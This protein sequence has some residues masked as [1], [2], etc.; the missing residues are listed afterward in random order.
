MQPVEMI[1]RNISKED[2]PGNN[3]K[4]VVSTYAHT[5]QSSLGLKLVPGVLAY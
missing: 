1:I 3:G 4:V 2:E 5:V